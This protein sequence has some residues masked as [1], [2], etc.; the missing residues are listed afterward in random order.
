MRWRVSWPPKCRPGRTNIS[1]HF[2]PMESSSRYGTITKGP[3]GYSVRI[4]RLFAYP[5]EQVWQ[6]IT[7]PTKVAIWLAEVTMELEEGAP[8]RL[9]FTNTNCD[10]RGEVTRIKQPSLLEYTWQ[11][12]QE[13]PSLV[14]W[15]LFPVG[16]MACRL[17]LTHQQLTGD[18]SSFAAGWHVHLDILEELLND[19]VD[20][21][22]WT[23]Q[24]WKPKYEEYKERF[25]P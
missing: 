25:K 24:M 16:N 9:H 6:A 10:C 3:E 2:I 7:D 22:Y 4:E 18:V 19:K 21:F 14:R 11:L 12:E 13:P 1:I 17:V 5:M 23:W 20:S 8:M 15:E